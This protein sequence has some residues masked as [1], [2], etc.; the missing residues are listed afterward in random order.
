MSTIVE[1]TNGKPPENL[2]P[3]RIVSPARSGPCCFCEMEEIGET[4]REERWEY[5]YKRCR[6]CGFTVQVILREVPNEALV[7]R[8]RKELQHSFRRNVPTW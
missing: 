1:Y 4:Q 5:V 3:W 8:L 6:Q 2:Y 7:A